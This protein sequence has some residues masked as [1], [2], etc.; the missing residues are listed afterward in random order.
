LER[1]NSVGALKLILEGKVLEGGGRYYKY[2]VVANEIQYSD[3]GKQWKT[4]NVT[5]NEFLKWDSWDLIK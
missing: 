3:E 5:I 2:D 4:S 1:V